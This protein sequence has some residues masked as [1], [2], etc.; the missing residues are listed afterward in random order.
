[1]TKKRVQLIIFE[2]LFLAVNPIIL[3]KGAS[4]TD[5]QKPI[6]HLSQA[7]VLSSN[8][9]SFSSLASIPQSIPLQSS[10]LNDDSI[11]AILNKY[12]NNLNLHTTIKPSASDNNENKLNVC[13]KKCAK[14]FKENKSIQNTPSN[15]YND[16]KG[17]VEDDKDRF[18]EALLKLRVVFS[19]SYNKSFSKANI[20]IVDANNNSVNANF[21]TKHSTSPECSNQS[22]SLY[23]ARK[24]KN[25]KKQA[26]ITGAPQNQDVLITMLQKMAQCC[27]DET[28]K[29]QIFSTIDCLRS[30]PYKKLIFNFPVF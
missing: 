1:M 7:S 13:D 30:L 10:F 15:S 16:K 29:V 12:K 27:D 22:G 20:D 9:S 6:H 8:H 5:L 23:A 28:S 3:N 14:Q 4:G 21:N 19:K 18:E 26:N 24:H 25:L 11:D 17:I 2:I